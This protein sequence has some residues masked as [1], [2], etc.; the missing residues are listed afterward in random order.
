MS[1]TLVALITLLPALGLG[2]NLN[3]V[4]RL[5]LFGV[6]VCLSSQLVL[7]I[8]ENISYSSQELAVRK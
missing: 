2:M 6:F 4:F 8:Q 5:S 3:F 1:T 7:I